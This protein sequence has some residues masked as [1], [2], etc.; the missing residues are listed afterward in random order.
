MA[1]LQ[2]QMTHFITTNQLDETLAKKVPLQS[3]LWFF[4]T[5]FGQEI[6]ANSKRVKREQPF[7]MLKEAQDVYLDFDEEG[8]ELLIHGMIDGYIEY[9]DHVVLYDFKTDSFIKDEAA[10][11]QNYQGQLRLYKEALQE[12]LNKP[13]ADVYLI[14]LSAKKIIA[15]KE[16]SL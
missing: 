8:A 4:E 12:A 15:L 1:Y 6:L 9:D 10:F 14:A 3:I 13:V 11:I 2:S 5:D 7:S 16:K